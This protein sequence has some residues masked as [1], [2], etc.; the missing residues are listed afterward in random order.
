M[1]SSVTLP[2]S[3]GAVQL[4]RPHAENTYY[5]RDI[6]GVL[7][8]RWLVFALVFTLVAAPSIWLVASLPPTYVATTRVLIEPNERLRLNVES[9]VAGITLD[10]ESVRSEVEVLKSPNLAQRV[11][12]RLPE[13]VVEDLNPKKTGIFLAL[14]YLR[15]GQEHSGSDE[16]AEAPLVT[17]FLQR[18]TVT[19]VERSRVITVAYRAYDPEIA[20]EVANAL[21]HEYIE[22]ALELKREGTRETA[23]WLATRMA[24]L[25]SSLDATERSIEAHRTRYDLTQG[26]GTGLIGERLSQANLA[27]SQ[28][29]SRLAEISARLTRIGSDPSLERTSEALN[30]QVIQQLRIQ[31]AA[32]A[33][34]V[35]E[36]ATTNGVASPT[37]VARRNALTRVRQS[38]SEETARIRGSMQ[39]EAEAARALQN[40][41]QQE[42]ESLTRRLGEL[43]T[44][45]IGLRALE[46]D[47]GATRAIYEN[48][49]L[50]IKDVV[51]QESFLRRDARIIG[52]AVPP[53][54]PASLSPIILI[55]ACIAAGLLAASFAL[56]V[57]V[58][59]E[60]GFRR[61]QDVERAT[62]IS[63]LS[64]IPKIKLRNEKQNFGGH[65]SDE[66][67]SRFAES[68]DM[69]LGR[70][71][72][73][74]PGSR[75][76]VVTIGSCLPGEGKTYVSLSLAHLATHIGY[77]CLVID[78]DVRAPRLTRSLGLQASP[79]LADVLDQTRELDDVIAKI[80][81]S[82]LCFLGVGRSTQGIQR[83]LGSSL[84]RSTIDKLTHDFDLI[85]ID[86]SPLTV[87]AEPEIFA[88]VADQTLLVVQWNRTPRALVQDC[89]ARLSK[90]TASISGIVLSQVRS[91]NGLE[92]YEDS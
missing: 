34:E 64:A 12:D 13:R 28:A 27:L 7:R 3:P 17:R 4:H 14:S 8:E 55:G 63:V 68:I 90:A 40:S 22:M 25:K 45:T 2:A 52:L 51:A 24:E 72:I 33:K 75:G 67:R 62:R 92:A 44:A 89:V 11:L 77:R 57:I 23:D 15:G 41:L 39:S 36:L 9:A 43:R 76:T 47:A 59:F 54:Y 81:D 48:V 38:I 46:R 37:L 16:A 56:R 61:I 60:P 49:L 18:I 1:D 80:G 6:I 73:G 50:R 69:L 58:H 91:R 82:G 53:T 66:Q 20:A 31:E 29:R 78:G 74:K 71:M 5:L 32:L 83:L 30:S 21:A 10:S 79:G 84:F 88:Q 85:I 87:A 70:I 26:D 19:P 35:A 86:T 42:I 65:V